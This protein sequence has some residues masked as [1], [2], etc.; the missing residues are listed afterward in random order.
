MNHQNKYFSFT[1]KDNHMRIDQYITDY[2]HQHDILITRSQLQKYF[3]A[4]VKVNDAQVKRNYTVHK[5]DKIF[6]DLT[7]YYEQQLPKHVLPQAIPFK[8]IYEDEDLMVLDKPNHLVVHPAVG[9]PDHTLL[10]GLLYHCQKLS[11]VNGPLRLGIVHRLDKDTTGLLVVAKNNQVHNALVEQLQN[12]TM[13]RYYQAIVEGVLQE[14]EG[15]IKAPVGRSY[16]DPLKQSVLHAMNPKRAVT[17]FTVQAKTLNFSY[18]E[19]EL[20]TGRTHQIRVHMQYIKHPVLG[21]EKYGRYLDDFKQYLHAYKLKFKH[22]TK[23]KFL[24]FISPL[25]N[26]FQEKLKSLSLIN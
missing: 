1:S 4:M 10:N 6:I 3:K 18:L 16:K 9:H 7:I 24:E 5:N 13:K 14:Q 2:L 21:D 20:E 22:P 26:H 11:D 19:C 15:I 25:P 23:N 17:Y 8:I 12:H